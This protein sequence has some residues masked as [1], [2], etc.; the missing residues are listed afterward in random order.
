MEEIVK[1]I[2]IIGAGGFARE[3]VWLIEENNKIKPEWN[4]L[5]YIS[6]ETGKVGNYDIV[7]DDEWLLNYNSEI[8]AVCC[9]GDAILR[10]KVV[11]KFLHKGNI[12]FHNSNF[13][14]E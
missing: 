10:E 5:G 12:H 6:N 11:S 13:A 7:G 3:V 2:V 14:L 9:I 8:Y 4:I 1:D